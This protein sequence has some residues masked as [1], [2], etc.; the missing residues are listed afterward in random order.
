MVQHD[1]QLNTHSQAMN[2]CTPTTPWVNRPGAD[3][4]PL[5]ADAA[6]KMWKAVRER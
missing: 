2:V 3:R 6:A 1:A 4:C 5:C